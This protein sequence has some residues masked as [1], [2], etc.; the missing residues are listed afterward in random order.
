MNIVSIIILLL[1]AL[2]HYCIFIIEVF[3]W[4]K[5]TGLR[6]FNLTKQFA[7]QTK[8]MAINQGL[9]NSFLASGIV[10]S[11][12]T[13]QKITAIFFIGCIFIAGVIGGL[14]SNKKIIFIQSVPATFALLI[15]ILNF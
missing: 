11:I 1:I 12:L 6:A 15:I 2:L 13:S 10:F 5:P 8:T 4:T 14:T 7:D 9:Y 3:F